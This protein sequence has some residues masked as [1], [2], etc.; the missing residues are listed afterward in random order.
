MAV[1]SIA[2]GNTAGQCWAVSESGQPAAAILWDQG[3]NVF[4]LSCGRVSDTVVAECA[5]LFSQKIRGYAVSGNLSYFRICAGSRDLEEQLPSVLPDCDLV[6]RHKVFYGLAEDTR[7]SGPA[8]TPEGLRIVSIDRECLS[9]GKYAGIDAIKAEINWMWTSFERYFGAGFGYAAV[10][11]EKIVCWCTSEYV[12]SRM[13][14]I[15]IETD[16]EYRGRGIATATTQRF[17]DECRTRGIR[18]HWECDPD[19]RASVRVAQK[20][21]FA[22]LDEMKCWAGRFRN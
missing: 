19:N 14:G 5:S 13:C 3:N 20:A 9:S 21:G 16:E 15:G 6:P 18:P 1:E 2:E 12:S 17:L 22:L 8:R 11:N 7:V 4:Y 10:L